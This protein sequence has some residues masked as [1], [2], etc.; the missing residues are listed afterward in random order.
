VDLL[1]RRSPATAET[2]YRGLRQ[3]FRWAVE[4]G[5]ITASP[6]ANAS[7]PKIPE[8]HIDVLTDE[9]LRALLGTCDPKT[10]EGRRDEAILRVF[11]DSGLRLAEVTNLRL[12]TEDDGSDVDLNTGVLRVVRK[13]RRIGL[14]PI[15]ART[16]KA[17]DRYLRLR[18]RHTYAD[19][20][21]LWIGQ[22]GRM[23]GSGIRQM[24]WRR[25]EAAGLKR[26]V[27]PHALRHS[28]AHNMMAAGASDGDLMTLAGWRTRTML[29][30]YA[31]ST[32][33]DRAVATH[34]RLSPGDRL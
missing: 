9:E 26:R 34:R 14:A 33:Q 3:F 27:H 30:R 23:T 24:T 19:E 11:M 28:W 10:F 17:L 12:R 31:S 7:P 2:R 6:M 16:I 1:E 5:E 21:W 13:G 32:A 29:Q 22:K 20:P 8:R 18:M 4:E 25:S 15:G